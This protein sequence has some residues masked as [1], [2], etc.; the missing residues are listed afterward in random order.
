MKIITVI[1]DENNYGF[2]NYLEPS[3]IFYDLE[4]VTLYW[5][6]DK[7]HSHRIKDLL[8]IN[9]I[10]KLDNDEVLLFTDGYDT[11]FLSSGNEIIEKFSQFGKELVFSAERNCW[12][13]P[14]LQSSYPSNHSPFR[15]LN[16]GAFIGTVGLIKALLNMEIKEG[17]DYKW[18]NQYLW[19]LRYLAE[20]EKIALDYTC[21]IFYPTSTDASKRKY[22]FK[23]DKDGNK[24]RDYFHPEFL[25]AE[26][27]KILGE[28]AF[29]DHRLM[30]LVTQTTPC[31]VHFNSPIGQSL[32]REKLLD[33]IKPWKPIVPF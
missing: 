20:S 32:I 14:E 26:K 4:L 25:R 17:G 11:S 24:N 27:N 28:I 21:E 30:N 5:T 1:S 31:H 10:N 22:F 9:Y 6:K 19:T 2:K 16:S 3:C 23:K 33:H 8:L 7:Y 18:S 12:P 15:Y 29:V 13:A